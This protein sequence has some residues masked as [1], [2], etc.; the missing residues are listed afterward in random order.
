MGTTLRTPLVRSVA[1]IV[2][3]PLTAGLLF[4]AF[5]RMAS[6]LYSYPDGASD[7]QILLAWARQVLAEKLFNMGLHVLIGFT[8]FMLLAVA[9]RFRLLLAVVSSFCFEGFLIARYCYLWGVAKYFEYNNFAGTVVTTLG[10]PLLGAAVA[11]IVLKRWRPLDHG[12]ERSS[13]A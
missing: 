11:L 7:S 6:L 3:V 5:H 8:V 12:V 1:V 4:W 10:L 2:L 9:T 13:D